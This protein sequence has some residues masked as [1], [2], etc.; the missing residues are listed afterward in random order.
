MMKALAIACFLSLFLFGALNAQI[1]AVQLGSN[2]PSGVQ[3][4]VLAYIKKG[5][6]FPVQQFS[7]TESPLASLAPGSFLLSFGLTLTSQQVL[8]Y[9]K[10]Q[11]G[12][13]EAMMVYS[14]SVN[15]VIRLIGDGNPLSASSPSSIGA[16]FASYRILEILG[17]AFL[18]PFKPNVPPQ[19]L[20]PSNLS[21]TVQF[22]A[23]R[24]PFR[25]T[26]YHTEHPLELTEVLQGM[27]LNAS[28]D[29][30]D[31]SWESMLPELEMFAQW[32]I[33]TRQNRIEWLILC[34]QSWYSFCG[35]ELRGNRFK[36]IIKI[37]H[38]FGVLTGADLPI[39]EKQQQ[40][41]YMIQKFGNLTEELA[42]IEERLDWFLSLGFDF[43]STESG[44]SEFTHPDESRMLTWMAHAADYAA[45]KGSELFIK[46]H[47][48]AGQLCKDYKDPRTG[49]PLNFNFL[50]TMANKTLGVYAHTVQMYSFDDP[51]PTY[52]NDNFTYMF[53]YMMY[54]ASRR[55]TVYHG[56]TA[57]WVNYD[58]DVPLHLPL[59]ASARLRDLRKVAFQEKGDTKILGQMNFC[60]G[61]EWSYWLNEAATHRAAW[62]PH[63]EVADENEALKVVLREVLPV[64]GDATEQVVQVIQEVVSA[65]YQLLVLGQVT[66]KDRPV[67]VV[68]NNGI[69]YLEGWDTWSE[70]GHMAG[71]METQPS[72]LGIMQ[73]NVKSHKPSYSDIAPLL[74]EMADKFTLLTE[75]LRKVSEIVPAYTKPLLLD[76]VDSMNMTSLRAIQVNA[77]YEYT[78]KW[79]FF[80]NKKQKELLAISTDAMKKASAVVAQREQQ[81]GVPV[82]R[83]ASWRK[84]P[85]VYSY[86]YLWTV[87]SLFYMRRDHDKASYAHAG[88]VSPCYM[89]VIDPVV[90]AF[91]EG[92]IADITK[93]LNQILKKVPGVGLVNEC[94]APPK[95][96][97]K[98]AD[99]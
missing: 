19:L 3:K 50:P 69:A 90:T 30:A 49:D 51:A 63:I 92:Q 24:W 1:V 89:N 85:T 22:E 7:E 58:I 73:A 67:D 29:P 60:S 42:Q 88:V 56:E 59:Y 41:W 53:D 72:R 52:G 26:H 71:K 75:K 38:D 98:Y 87:H 10:L 44:S 91:G 57:Y 21:P 25:G 9:S 77:L 11:N 2:L 48:S 31:P 32:H 6:Q 99:L 37:F 95:Q 64:F 93:T 5:A 96:E 16:G 43:I 84:N 62:N 70:I 47:C 54:E 13:T 55:P 74:Q 14:D 18:H 35:S 28:M 46:A 12:G 86:G 45:Q 15:G 82:E 20:K 4:N 17:F 68:K 79:S 34:G 27:G 40:A 61:F 80:A 36:T 83:I 33:A 97:P 78:G 39:A 76:M 65:E 23:P 94:L 8:D 66:G 81:Y